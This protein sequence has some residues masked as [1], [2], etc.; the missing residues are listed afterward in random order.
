M[1]GYGLPRTMDIEYPDLYDIAY[2]GLKTSTGRI[3]KGRDD[4]GSQRTKPKQ[5]A[6]RRLKKAIRQENKSNLRKEIESLKE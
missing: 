6:R 5:I 1:K 2:Y 3:N 4:H